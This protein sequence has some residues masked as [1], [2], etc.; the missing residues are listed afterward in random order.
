MRDKIHSIM[1]FEFRMDKI[2]NMHFHQTPEI[3]Y[4]LDGAVEVEVENEKY[5]LEKGDIL[6]VNANKRHSVRQVEGEL[7]LAQFYI[8]FTLLSEAMG[9]NRILFWCN[10]AADRNDAYEKLKKVLD[11]ILGQYYNREKEGGLHLN[12]ICYEAVYLLT[13]YFMVK[14]DDTRLK[15][16]LNPDSSRVFEIQNYVQSNYMKQI[17]LNDLAQKLYLTNAY[18]SKYIKKRFGL[19]FIEYVNNVRLFHAVDEL[20]YSDRKI[21]RIALDNGF[22][23][24]AAF[25]KAFK[26]VYH[27]TPSAYR[28]RVSGKDRQEQEKAEDPH[29]RKSF[30]LQGHPD[31]E[32][33]ETEALET[34]VKQYLSGNAVVPEESSARFR[35]EV[36]ADALKT[37]K[38]EMPWK[39]II[40]IGRIDEILD[41]S[42][43]SQL[44][45][46][47]EEIGFRYVR[48]WNI[49][50]EEMYEEK[51]GEYHYNFSRL[52]RCIDFLTEHGMKPYIELSFKPIHV[53]YSINSSLANRDNDIIFH[54]WEGYHTVMEEFAVHLANRYGV[55]EL[56]TWYF[57]LWKDER[58]NML[59]ENGRYFECF[60]TGWHALKKISDR[61]KVGGAG[62]ALAYDRYQYRELIR[63]WKKREIRP[64]FISVYSYS[65]LLLRQDGIYFGKRSLDGDF[66][67]NQL[68]FFE[69]IL[70]EEDFLPDELHVT[71]WNFTISNRNCISDSCAQG[72]YVMKT[73]LD[74]VGR[75]DKLG[76][77]HGS[78]LHSEYFD[79]GRVLCGDNGLLTR[80]GIRKP[81]FYAFHFLNFLQPYL[82]TR[83]KNAVITTN[84]KGTYVI[85][86]HNYKRFNYRY[87]LKEEK[88]IQIEDMDEIYEDLD[89][90]RLNFAVKNVENGEYVVRMFYINR[91]NGSIQDLWKDMA[92]MDNL[93]KGEIDYMRRCAM[94]KV[95]MRKIRVSDH[96]LR[97]ETEMPAHEIRLI[98]IRYL[99]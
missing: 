66:L 25:N 79:S 12:G 11:Q 57:E 39:E 9:T 31:G 45:L 14:A 20:L 10:S 77:W 2:Q 37:E 78:D 97:I 71:E 95:E 86:C 27:V 48:V 81:S 36:D 35:T 47:Q 38:M 65:Y 80:D 60:E 83:T 49:F 59:E 33:A 93:A 92:Y 82:L 21:T 26:E 23:T 19:S 7:L 75:M 84:K 52:D 43:Q 98:D 62:F 22:P 90:V 13:S 58:I 3:V 87:T 51:K 6:L 69:Q 17:S 96:I 44:L 18:L 32:A 76:Y 56:E 63:N 55:E 40:N 34:R 74:A 24:T 64:D 41:S 91:E 30:D 89:P 94:P 46:L 4:V 54:D 16:Q 61:I 28:L 70:K 1:D 8:N 15:E 29:V 53:A 72:A 67:Q 88:D 50:E 5:R 42:I 85:A 68:A 73:C 99:Y